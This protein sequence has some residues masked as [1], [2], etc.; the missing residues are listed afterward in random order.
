M[1]P[2]LRLPFNGDFPVTFPF[3]AVPTDGTVKKKYEEW[4]LAAHNGIDYGLPEGTEVLA[5]DAGKVIQ[6]GRNADFGI[7]VT[8]EHPWGQSLYAH[9]KEARVVN[10]QEVKAGDVIGLSGQTGF[11]KGPHLH[12]GVKLAGAQENDGYLGFSDPAPFF[13][14]AQ[15]EPAQEVSV[16]QLVEERIKQKLD[17]LRQKA[18]EARREKREENLSK[19]LEMLAQNGEVNNS[20]VRTSLIISR[21]TANYYLKELVER[22]KI[23]MDK[24]GRRTVYK[25][26]I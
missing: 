14:K 25:P 1:Q 18:N 6:V 13:A 5:A 4:G 21:R 10:G 16:E 7:S 11:A 24:K 22:G 19:I 3:G 20:L 26:L 8:L 23:R 2:V 15:E 12:F 9:L 17:Q